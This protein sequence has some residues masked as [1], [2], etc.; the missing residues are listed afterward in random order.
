MDK[1]NSFLPLKPDSVNLPEM[2]LSTKLKRKTFEDSTLV[3][4]L[5]PAKYVTNTIAN[6]MSTPNIATT[7]PY[8]TL[9]IDNKKDYYA[10]VDSRASDN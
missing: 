9:A 10:I 7:N 5:S 3:W 4:G 1:I 6:T 8:T 2:Y